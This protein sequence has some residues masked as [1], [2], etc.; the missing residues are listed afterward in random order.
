MTFSYAQSTRIYQ[1]IFVLM[2]TGSWLVTFFLTSRFLPYRL[3]NERE[4]RKS[5]PGRFLPT[6]NTRLTCLGTW[7]QDWFS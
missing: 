7:L 4:K 1:G 2:E 5:V 6:I 3:M